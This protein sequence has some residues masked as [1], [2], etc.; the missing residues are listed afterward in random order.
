M[1]FQVQAF[2]Q[3]VAHFSPSPMLVVGYIAIKCEVRDEA[4]DEVFL[5]EISR[6]AQTAGGTPHQHRIC[7][8]PVLGIVRENVLQT[9][10]GDLPVENELGRSRPVEHQR[11]GRIPVRRGDR[12]ISSPEDDGGR[13]WTIIGFLSFGM[14]VAYLSRSNLAVA[15]TLPD[16]VK[17]FHLSDTDR[18]TLNSS[19]FWAYA[20][21]QIPAGWL[22]D[23][24][25]VKWP[26]ALGFLLDR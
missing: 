5:T 8:E 6:N 17:A 3:F 1:R 19:F 24:Y 11:I 15:L 2:G 21:L 22:V 10:I 23:R 26:Y 20:V 9:A 25:G 14:I 16:L 4:I 13:R 7:V 12:A 18:G